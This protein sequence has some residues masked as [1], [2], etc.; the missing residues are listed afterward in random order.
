MEG[1]RWIWETA[2]GAG[3]GEKVKSSGLLVGMPVERAAGA[4]EA[5]GNAALGFGREIAGAEAQGPLF[6]RTCSE[7]SFPSCCAHPCGPGLTLSW[8]MVLTPVPASCQV[9]L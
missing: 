6:G 3:L 4:T 5:V 7:E 2:A 1:G 8:Q 9:C